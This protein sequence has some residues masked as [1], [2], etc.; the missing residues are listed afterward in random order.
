MIR[1]WTPWEEALTKTVLAKLGIKS[2]EI[3]SAQLAGVNKV[4]RILDW[5]EIDLYVKRK[6]KVDRSG[7]PKLF[8]DREFVL[9][10]TVTKLESSRIYTRIFCVSGFVFS[11][12]SDQPIRPIAFRDAFDMEVLEVDS[13]FT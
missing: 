9:A 13:R 11:F 5:R 1:L 2:Q 3:V 12:E 7:V 10:K 8:D 4:Q 6:G